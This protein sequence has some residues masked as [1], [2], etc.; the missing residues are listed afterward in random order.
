M[1]RTDMDV[2]KLNEVLGSLDEETWNWAY[3]ACEDFL[4]FGCVDRLQV[5]ARELK[6]TPEEILFW[7]CGGC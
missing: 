2:E 6:L 3:N 7:F 1:K 4:A 5:I